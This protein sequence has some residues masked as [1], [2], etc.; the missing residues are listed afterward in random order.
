MPVKTGHDGSVPVK[1]TH[2]PASRFRGNDGLFP[3][4]A[5]MCFRG[6]GDLKKTIGTGR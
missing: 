3:A 1:K 2:S 5:R 6:N 4:S